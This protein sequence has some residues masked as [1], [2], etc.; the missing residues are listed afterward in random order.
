MRARVVV[1]ACDRIRQ[2]AR[3]LVIDCIHDFRPVQRDARNA[4]VALVEDFG[5]VLLPGGKDQILAK[6]P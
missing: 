2:R 1:G 4:T 3:Q 5:H 6:S